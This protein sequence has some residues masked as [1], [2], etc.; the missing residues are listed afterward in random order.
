[1]AT[2]VGFVVQANVVIAVVIF[3]RSYPI[4]LSTLSIEPNRTL[5][6]RK[7]MDPTLREVAAIRFAR[8]FAVVVA[9]FLKRSNINQNYDKLE[10]CY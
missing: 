10:N 3:S 7:Y 9:F 5:S 8:I 6:Y 2:F 4:F 1:M